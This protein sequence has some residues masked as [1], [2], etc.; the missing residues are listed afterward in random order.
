MAN[1]KPTADPTWAT[2]GNYP[3]GSNPWS[4]QSVRSVPSSGK[5]GTGYTPGTDD[6]AEEDNNMLGVHGDL[7]AWM[8]A[9]QFVSQLTGRIYSY[10]FMESTIPNFWSVAVTGTASETCGVDESAEGGFGGLGVNVGAGSS[11][12][13]ITAVAM[14]VGTADFFMHIRARHSG[15]AT[16][17]NFIFG[18]SSSTSAQ[19]R[20][21]NVTSG[22]SAA[23]TFN[24]G[25]TSVPLTS[26][27]FGNTYTDFVVQRLAGELTVELSGA[28]VFSYGPVADTTNITGF[29]EMFNGAGAADSFIV[30]KFTLLVNE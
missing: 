9:T 3:A 24:F 27:L 22:G 18:L 28:N 15:V 2:G 20:N 23:M 26:C 11:N 29:M 8:Q 19:R 6:A 7:L 16:H 30:D 5:R 4:G 10:D 17:Y 13:D 12:I 14:P 1:S 25:T 21:F